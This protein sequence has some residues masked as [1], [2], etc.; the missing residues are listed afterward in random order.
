MMISQKIGRWQILASA[1][2]YCRSLTCGIIQYLAKYTIAGSLLGLYFLYIG[3][4]GLGMLCLFGAGFI[5]LAL[6]VLFSF[7]HFGRHDHAES[8]H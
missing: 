5:C 6:D 2:V 8:A 4:A 3:E 1:S 7:V